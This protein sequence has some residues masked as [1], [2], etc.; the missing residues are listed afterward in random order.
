M[1]LY[2]FSRETPSRFRKE[3]IKAAVNAGHVQGAVE[4]DTLNQ[5]LVNIGSS[6]R[7]SDE[8]L[9]EILAAA[10]NKGE[11]I[12]PVDKMLKLM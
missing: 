9:N 10:G 2:S 5:V 12:I 1:F 7:L 3:L 11:R 6:E 8:E 4:V